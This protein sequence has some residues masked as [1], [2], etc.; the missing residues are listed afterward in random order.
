MRHRQAALSD[1]LKSPPQ[2]IPSGLRVV[3]MVSLEGL[4]DV[5]RNGH[6][7]GLV[8]GSER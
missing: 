6:C 2:L 1:V 5:L 4:E 7:G 3:Q 8:G